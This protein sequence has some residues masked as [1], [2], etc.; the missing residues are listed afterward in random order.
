MGGLYLKD[1]TEETLCAFVALV[2]HPDGLN[3]VVPEHSRAD[4]AMRVEDHV[5]GNF[6]G[7]AKGRASLISWKGP[8]RCMQLTTIA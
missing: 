3:H 2:L 1:F 5:P 8:N 6:S 4:Y 7:K